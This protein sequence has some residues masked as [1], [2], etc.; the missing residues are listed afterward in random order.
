MH[1]EEPPRLGAGETLV[2][3]TDVG[4]CGSDLHWFGEG[5]IGDASLVAPVVPGHEFAGVVEGG[6]L[7]GRLVAVDPSIPCGSCELCY[8]GHRNLCPTV[9][10]AGH[11][12]YDGALRE[13]IAWPTHLIHP[14]PT[15]F[16][17]ADGALLEPLGVALHAWDLGHARTASTVAVVGAGPIGLLLVQ[18]AIG[19][20]AHRVIAVDP[21]PHRREAALKAGATEALSP[22]EAEDAATWRGLTG[23]GCDIAFEVAG[24]DSGIAA[25][26]TAARP[27][28]RVV[29]LGIPHDDRS[30]FPAGVTR[31]KGLTLLLVRRMKEMYPRAITLVRSGRVDLRSLVSNQYPLAESLTAFERASTRA[32]LKV[33]IR[34]ND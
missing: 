7:D 31:R 33:I 12:S 5:G 22:D 23:L 15:S 25:A 30:S 20:G 4:L 18:L 11:G 1:E 29:L 34:P 27:G 21:L 28:A 8:A 26:V 9:Q 17:G 32:G 10:F 16:T 19:T 2:R 6:P 14:L 3:I 24:N 13:V